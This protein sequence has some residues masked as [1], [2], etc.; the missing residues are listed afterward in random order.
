[1]PSQEVMEFVEGWRDGMEKRR[2]GRHG[3]QGD[4][5]L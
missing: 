3:S 4:S 2:E 1:M 5:W